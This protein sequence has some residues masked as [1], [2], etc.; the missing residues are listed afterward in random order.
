MS[1][2]SIPGLDETV[3]GVLMMILPIIIVFSVIQLGLMIAAL[4]SIFKHDTY[5]NGSRWLW[6]VIVILF[7]TI[8]PIL[9]FVV[10]RDRD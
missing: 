5:R 2:D 8:G 7:N 6:V 1:I 9:Y 4:V 10:G 3:M